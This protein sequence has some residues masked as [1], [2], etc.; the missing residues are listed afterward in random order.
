MGLLICS[1][2]TAVCRS[3]GCRTHHI[4]V[5]E[6]NHPRRMDVSLDL[7]SWGASQGLLCLSP[8]EPHNGFYHQ[9][10]HLYLIEAP[11]CNLKMKSLAPSG[12]AGDKQILCLNTWHSLNLKMLHIPQQKEQ[13]KYHI[14]HTIFALCG[15]HKG[16]WYSYHSVLLLFIPKISIVDHRLFFCNFN[17]FLS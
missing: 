12:I 7:S 17:L 14:P 2:A 9:S 15:H 3:L 8:T 10:A 13:L 16:C 4:I 11:N 1:L 6:S 5:C